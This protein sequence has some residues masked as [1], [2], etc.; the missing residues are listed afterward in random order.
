MPLNSR[1]SRK[2]NAPAA[3]A[4][5]S[6]LPA[7]TQ[8][9]TA[10]DDRAGRRLGDDPDPRRERGGADPVVERGDAPRTDRPDRSTATRTP[11]ATASVATAAVTTAAAARAA[12]EVAGDRGTEVTVLLGCGGV[13]G[14]PEVH[15]DEVLVV[16]LRRRSR[17]GLASSR[18]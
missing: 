7:P 13:E 11:V 15:D 16:V 2:W 6:R 18:S 14:V 3:S 4:G 12:T 17:A 9:D 8:T 10:A 5:S 1:C